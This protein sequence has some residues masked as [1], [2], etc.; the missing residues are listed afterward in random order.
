MPKRIEYEQTS[1]VELGASSR[2][3]DRHAEAVASS[4]TKLIDN[5]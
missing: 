1:S 5:S 4:L 3:T 2:R